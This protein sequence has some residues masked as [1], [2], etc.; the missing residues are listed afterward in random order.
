MGE[1]GEKENGGCKTVVTEKIQGTFFQ[2]KEE[3]R[4]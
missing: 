1:D 4:T 3:V 2:V